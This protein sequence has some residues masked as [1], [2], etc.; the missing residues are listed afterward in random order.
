MIRLNAE[1]R[2][3]R[4]VWLLCAASALGSGAF[5]GVSQLLNPLL[6]LRLG[7]DATTVGT[8]SALGAMSFATS[9]ILGG[10]LGTRLGARRIMILGV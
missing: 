2:Y 8:L 9:S 5:L 7:Y 3:S 4:D 6:V 10:L 1:H